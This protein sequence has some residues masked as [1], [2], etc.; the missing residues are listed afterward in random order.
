MEAQ[1][2]LAHPAHQVHLDNLDA[3]VIQ[4]KVLQDLQVHQVSQVMEDKVLKETKGIQV[5]HPVLDHTKVVHLDHLD[6]LDRRDP[7]VLLDQ[8]GIKVSQVNQEEALRQFPLTVEHMQ[9]KDHQDHQDLLDVQDHRDIK[10][11]S[12]LL[13]LLVLLALQEAKAFL[14]PQVLLVLQAS[15]APLVPPVTC[16]STSLTI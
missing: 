13:V 1:E 10:V 15:Q 11:T 14:V 8:E 9:Y 2:Y 3:Q 5:L 6:L 4:D 16:G 12:D 7:Q